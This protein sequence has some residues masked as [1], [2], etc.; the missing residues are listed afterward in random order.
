MKKVY[1]NAS[2]MFISPPFRERVKRSLFSEKEVSMK[3][4]LKSIIV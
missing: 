1:W 2:L 4:A 3:C